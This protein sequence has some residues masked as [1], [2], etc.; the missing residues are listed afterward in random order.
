MAFVTGLLLI[1]APAA[2]LNNLGSIPGEREDN[3]V[4][5][6]VI[7]TKE[8]AYPYVS[9]QA[10]RYWLRTT[11]E[12]R[13]A[14]W[15]AAPIYREEKVA[16]T[17]ANPLLYWDDDLFG[18][19]RAPS[20]RETAKALRA[21]DTS[22]AGETETTDTITRVAPFRVSTLVSLAPVTPTNDFG[23]MSRH[24]GNPVPHEHQFYRAT[25]K[26]L[27]SLNLQACGTFSYR[28]K[29]GFR[30]L[31][32]VRMKLAEALEGC[33]HLEAEKSFRLP[34][35][36]RVARVQALF[37]G[38]A[39][40]EGGA[41][42]TLHYTDVSPAL[43]LL[44]VTKGGNH[45]FHHA[46]GAN[47]VGQPEI[48]AKALE[49][50][51]RVYRDGLLSPVYVGWVQGYLDAERAAFEQ[52]AASY[53]QALQAEHPDH[54]ALIQIGHPRE[55]FQQLVAGFAANPRWLD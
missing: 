49:E 27:F 17:D 52:F 14:G 55:L 24:E 36:Q 15:Q 47:R 2:A 12:T 19:M 35:A 26:G 44:A 48:K 50:A 23:T 46:V 51:L 30:N 7:K 18:Y 16:Y 53:N 20:K 29:T 37:E 1:D 8:G 11:L 54:P 22:R 5:V 42:Q 10:L 31:D 38:M 6:K 13:V 45:I 40:L 25:L 43:V 34:Q 4:G 39:Q 28:N 33:E 9:A 32:D 21:A 3:T 41:K